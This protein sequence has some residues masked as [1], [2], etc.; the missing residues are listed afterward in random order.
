MIEIP[1]TQLPATTVLNENHL[2]EITDSTVISRLSA[3]APF[4]SQTATRQVANKATKALQ[5]AELVKLDIPF[6]QLT[7]SKDFAGAARGYMHGGRALRHK[8]I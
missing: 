2:A 4:A 1:I 3:L 5:G 8:Q 7:K 6:S